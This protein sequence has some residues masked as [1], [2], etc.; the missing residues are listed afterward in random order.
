M[1]E[2]KDNEKK[3]LFMEIFITFLI[4]LG[5]GVALVFFTDKN[6][7]TAKSISEG[8]VN[9]NVNTDI[10]KVEIDVTKQDGDLITGKIISVGPT[11][12][13]E[14]TP[15][16]MDKTI[17]VKFNGADKNQVSNMVPGEHIVMDVDPTTKPD[18]DPIEGV[19]FVERH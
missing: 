8:I 16:K 7:P 19:E 1:K 12:S 6:A 4:I 13:E 18:A 2:K 10:D 3:E 15:F 9:D 11:V 5:V 17:T 14:T